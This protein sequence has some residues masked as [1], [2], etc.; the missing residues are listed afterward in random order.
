MKIVE[1][2]KDIRQ[3]AGPGHWNDPDMLEVGRAMSLNEDRAHFS[4]WCL[5]A[6]PLIAGNDLRSMSPEVAHIL[7]NR[8]VIAV[9]QDSLGVQGFRYDAKDSLE[10]WVKPLSNG[11]WAVCFLNRS[12]TLRHIDFDWSKNIVPD[13]ISKCVLNT[14][15][16]RY[17]IRDLW[18]GDSK[19]T[20]KKH[21]T[22]DVS[23]HDVLLVRLTPR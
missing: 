20:T 17:S 10:V 14:N 4:L 11:N 5:M 8:E 3:Y 6:A 22:A 19:G 16:T 13:D 12:S 9:D 23:S 18:S 21:L 1:M 2:R 7:G 15:T